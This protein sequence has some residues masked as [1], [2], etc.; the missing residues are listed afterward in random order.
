MDK[1]K[2]AIIAMSC[3]GVF[4]IAGLTTGS[5]YKMNRTAEYEA[6]L[7]Q[8]QEE[9]EQAKQAAERKAAEEKLKALEVELP[10][11]KPIE[12][13][14][15][16]AEM[17]K[18]ETPAVTPPAVTPKAPAKKTEPPKVTV[19]TDNSGN[20]TITEEYKKPDPPKHEEVHDPE[21]PP[22]VPPS[23]P[24]KPGGAVDQEIKDEDVKFD[25]GGDQVPN[26]NGEVFVPGFGWVKS[27]PGG[28]SET[29]PNA[30]TGEVI[31][32]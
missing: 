8:Q 21:T 10:E 25:D 31:G 12:E 22:P 13:K 18:A 3:V 28:K 14:T 20:Q 1:R 16:E 11:I 2:I 17:P 9:M 32:Q 19:K 23:T 6:K 15:P 26:G 7:A 4:V 30:G 5:I 27:S 24:S 29:A